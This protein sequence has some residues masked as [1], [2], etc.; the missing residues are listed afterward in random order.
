MHEFFLSPRYGLV[1]P[2]QVIELGDFAL[3]SLN[4]ALKNEW[5]DNV[6]K[7]LTSVIPE[8]T[9]IIF[10]VQT[11]YARLLVNPIKEK[12]FTVHCPYEW[13][14][15]REQMKWVEEVLLNKGLIEKRLK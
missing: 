11:N 7:D 1:K 10:L 3:D 8:G 5:A 12:G 14:C 13:M 4:K 9:T 15:K 2:D 6:I